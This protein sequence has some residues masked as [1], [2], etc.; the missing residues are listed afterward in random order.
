MK[1]LLCLVALVFACAISVQADGHQP[2]QH[3]K[4]HMEYSR[5]GSKEACEDCCMK[6][7]LVMGV[8]ARKCRCITD[9]SNVAVKIKRCNGKEC[10]SSHALKIKSAQ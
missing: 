2:C 3:I 6:A 4:V 10:M 7:G 5:G 8:T 1:A 9:R